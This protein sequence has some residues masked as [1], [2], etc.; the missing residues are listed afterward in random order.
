MYIFANGVELKVLEKYGF[1][2]SLN[3]YPYNNIKKNG[4]YHIGFENSEMMA[5]D[6]DNGEGYKVKEL[7]LN[8]WDE[9]ELDIEFFNLLYDLIKDGIL[10]KGVEQ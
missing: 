5:Y 6:Y 9:T 3:N 1:K 10:E 8:I 7:E 4:H 2:K